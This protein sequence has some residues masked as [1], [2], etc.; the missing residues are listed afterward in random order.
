MD[1]GEFWTMYPRRV[2][3]RAAEKSWQRMTE[4]EQREALKALP[5]HVRHWRGKDTQYVPH[6]ATW[7]NQARWEDELTDCGGVAQTLEELTGGRNVVDFVA[8]RIG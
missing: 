4:D 7:L 1:F 8:R 2:A 3:K 5:A 6:P